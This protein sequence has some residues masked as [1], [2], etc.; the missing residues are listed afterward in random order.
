MKHWRAVAR[1]INYVR[2]YWIGNM[3]GITVI[4]LAYQ[5]P[6]LVN[7]EFFN[8][9]T[10]DA[11]TGF[12]LWSLV[13]LLFAGGLGRLAG[14]IFTVSTNVPLGY[15]IAALLQKNMLGRIFKLPGA[16][17]LE[18]RRERRSVA[19]GAMWTRHGGSPCESMTGSPPS[20]T[21]WCRSPSWRGWR[22]S[23]R[24]SR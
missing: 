23:I 16:S 1:S 7:R 6:G 11:P 8:L 19:S 18:G 14:M 20:S 4:F 22:G 2:W 17:A 3:G 9:I 21:E 24:T 10:G 5:V 12:N 13:A 15:R